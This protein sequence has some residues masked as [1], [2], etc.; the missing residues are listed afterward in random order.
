MKK[1]DNGTRN[2]GPREESR[3]SNSDGAPALS[4]RR[5]LGGAGLLKTAAAGAVAGAAL[6]PKRGRAAQGGGLPFLVQLYLRGGADGLTLV[7]PYADMNY[8]QAR[9]TTRV[10]PPLI[11]PIPA[12]ACYLPPPS[13]PSMRAI[14]LSNAGGGQPAFGTPQAMQTLMPKYNAGQ[15]S[16]VHACGSLDPTRSHFEQQLKM[17]QGVVGVADQSTGWLGRYLDL[18]KGPHTGPLRAYSF[19]PN[20]LDSFDGG[21]KMTSA[22]DPGSFAFPENP[23]WNGP[24][25]VQS[26]LANLYASFHGGTDPLL[27][28]FD[29]DVAAIAEL[30]QVTLPDCNAMPPVNCSPGYPD[31]KLGNEFRQVAAMAKALPML[32]MCA[33]NYDNIDGQRWDSHDDQGVHDGKMF[34]LMTNLAETLNAFLDDMAGQRPVV[35]LVITE[36]GRRLQENGSGGTDHGRGGVAMALSNYPGILNPNPSTGTGRVIATGWPGLA[37]GQLEDGL[38]LKV[39]IDVRDVMTEI[40]F[41]FLG[42]PGTATDL[43]PDTPTYVY[44]DRGV[45]A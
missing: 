8:C 13:S 18:T 4:R 22:V 26:T 16:F 6:M 34:N 45:L 33:V 17:E 11:N 19:S 38:D 30:A 36:F 31:S 12:T 44:Q 32:E 10:Y 24:L 39:A 14:H 1:N 25:T 35:V 43:F 3:R 41:K 28:T 27:T 20:P 7:C 5:L 37:P 23:N 15:L 42:F 2:S 29:T 21:E 9:D 40:A